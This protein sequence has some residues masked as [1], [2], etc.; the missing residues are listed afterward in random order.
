M[1]LG[2]SQTYVSAHFIHETN[3]GTIYRV[4]CAT[5]EL[6]LYLSHKPDS[7]KYLGSALFHMGES[8]NGL[9]GRT[10]CFF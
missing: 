1:V 5:F 7:V 4:A 10:F 9:G 6:Y 2:Y 8:V 3:T